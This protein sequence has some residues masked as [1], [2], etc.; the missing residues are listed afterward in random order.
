MGLLH[1]KLDQSQAILRE[2]GMDLW[3]TFVR[4]SAMF[5]DPAL[6][7]VVGANVTWQ[8]AFL[9]PS[10]GEALA[11]VGSLDKANMEERS[12][13]DRVQG[14]LE[15]IGE[16][17][18]AALAGTDPRRIAINYSLDSEI[19]DGLTHGM[20]LKLVEILEGTP[21]AA[22]LESSEAVLSALRGRKTPAEIARMRE[23]VA[24]TLE[25]LGEA[26]GFIRP[27]RTEKEVADFIVAQVQARGLELA[28]EQV[29]CPAVFSGPETAGAHASPTEG[30]VEPG[31]VLNIDFGV[32]VDGYCSDL[33]RTYYVPRK[34]EHGVPEPVL[35]G[36]QTIVEAISRSA[37]G[38]RPGVMGHEID[39]IAR[40]HIVQAGY[41]E[42]PHALG[43]QIGR[44]AHDGAGL[45]C[46]EWE[47]YGQRPYLKVEQYQVYTIEPRLNVEGFGIA[48]V[49]EMV[50]VGEQGCSFLGPRQEEVWIAG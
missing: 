50:Q 27:G 16:P 20:Y 30:R 44:K 13:F 23:A 47:R 29:H 21:Y 14:Y 12:A 7:T 24:V 1:E 49:E 34:G 28:W 40:D 26:R 45:L 22:R 31:H 9:V 19:A 32:R 39:R 4:E 11:I 36:M 42:Y 15:G 5:P 46:P 37:E 43:H 6:E 41:G 3:L 48:T 35:R 38:L 8:S 33:Q 2:L 17:L 10:K 25:I 18:R